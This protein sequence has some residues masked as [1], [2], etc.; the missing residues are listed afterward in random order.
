MIDY[1]GRCRAAVDPKITRREVVS[2]VA[3]GEYRNISFIPEIAGLVA[4]VTEENLSEALLP[5][6][7]SNPDL[8]DRVRTELSAIEHDRQDAQAAEKDP[9]VMRFEGTE[10]FF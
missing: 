5:K 2:R 10:L 4:D 1:D 7:E 3:F 6:G 8:R 9:F